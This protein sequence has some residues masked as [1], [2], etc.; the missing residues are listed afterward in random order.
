VY[1]DFK[2]YK[3]AFVKPSTTHDDFNASFSNKRSNITDDLKNHIIFLNYD[4]KSDI[5][6]FEEKK[7]NPLEFPKYLFAEIEKQTLLSKV[8]IET[9]EQ[10]INLKHSK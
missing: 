4:Y 7:T 5:G 2:N 10:K 3:Y 8:I 6:S 1:T 9:S